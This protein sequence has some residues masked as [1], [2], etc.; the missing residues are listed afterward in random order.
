VHLIVSVWLRSLEEV[1]E[2]VVRWASD[3]S[4]EGFWWVPAPGA[5]PIGGLV[6]HTGGASYRLMLRG[7][8]QEVPEA[9]RIRPAEE[10]APT[11]RD[12]QEVL[13]EFAENMNQVK[14]RLSSLE[15]EDLERVVKFNQYEVRAIYALDHIAAHAQHHAGQIITTRKLWTARNT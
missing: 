12:P 7:T 11:G 6:R 2:I 15:M 1:E 8:G 9:I 4:P 13:A 14:T 3:L 5:N 10:M